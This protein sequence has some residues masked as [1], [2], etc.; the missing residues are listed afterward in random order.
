[1]DELIEIGMLTAENGLLAKADPSIHNFGKM[2]PALLANYNQQVLEQ[3]ARALSR[4]RDKKYN[5]TLNMAIPSRLVPIL[6]E[7]IKRFVREL[8]VLVESH[9]ERDEVWILSVQM[10]SVTDIGENSL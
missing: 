9:T 4:G 10:F 8:D 5:E 7:Q 2:A 6:K 3:A 1:M